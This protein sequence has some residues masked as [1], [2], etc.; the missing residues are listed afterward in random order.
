MTC[1]SAINAS[2]GWIYGCYDAEMCSPCLRTCVHYVPGL[3][4]EAKKVGRPPVRTPGLAMTTVR[5]RWVIRRKDVT[6]K[7]QLP[8]TLKVLLKTLLNLNRQCCPCLAG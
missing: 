6:A 3:N 1:T 5:C 7:Q 4:S 8:L 2:C